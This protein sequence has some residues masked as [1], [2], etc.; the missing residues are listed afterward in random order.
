[1]S[2][3]TLIIDNIPP[4]WPGDCNVTENRGVWVLHMMMQNFLTPQLDL[5]LTSKIRPCV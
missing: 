4:V 1:M 2:L 3:K 5:S